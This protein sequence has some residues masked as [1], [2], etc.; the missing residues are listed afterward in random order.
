MDPGL[1]KTSVMYAVIQILKSQRLIKKTLVIC[2]LRPALNVWPTQKDRYTDFKSLKIGVLHG[3]AKDRLLRSLDADVYVVN[4]E[5]LPWLFGARIEV[6]GG[7]KRM[8][9]DPER[10][11]YIQQEFDMLIVDESTKFRDGSTLRFKILRQL[12]PLFKRRYILTGTPVPK[13]L[14]D[15]FGQIYILDEGLSLGR[16]ITHYR[17]KWFYP[18]GW[19]G[20]DWTP[21]AGAFE[22]VGAA[23]APLV[24]RVAAEGNLDLPETVYD[25][26]LVDLP[27]EVLP[28]YKKMCE[29]MIIRISNN[30]IIAANAAVASSKCR[31][32][33][34]GAIYDNGEEGNWIPL[35]EEKLD[36]LGDLIEQ[37]QGQ[38]LLVT[39]EFG[40]D[41]ERIAKRF[42]IPC[43]S[44]GNVNHDTSLIQKFS[45]GELSVVMGSP[46]S[47]SLGIDGLQHACSHIAMVGC[48]WNLLDYQQTI[49]RVRRS[50]SRASTV[51]VHRILSRN[52]VD[53]QIVEVL[54]DRHAT[55][56][57]FMNLLQ[58]IGKTNCS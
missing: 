54:N 11:A 16:Y 40:F 18:S 23:I 22:Q 50:G 58:T 8:V 19:G 28:L 31:Q 49:D 17:N 26:I 37:L 51:I 52:T 9:L 25:D 32:I 5:G 20:Y 45:R 2:P 21:K 46:A 39:Y 13:G 6:S 33:A 12:I 4:P 15:L 3:N 34:N 30:K 55:Q 1:G 42:G 57:S 36:A 43:I 48:T 41:R 14:L 38:P 47:I 53:Y 35:H 24:L 56:Q 27:A 29:E 44:T 10:V 7:R